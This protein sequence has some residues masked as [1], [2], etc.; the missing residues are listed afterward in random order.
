MYDEHY[1]LVEEGVA[2]FGDPGQGGP[3]DATIEGIIE[4][5]QGPDGGMMATPDAGSGGTD[6]GTITTGD[7]SH[8]NADAAIDPTHDAGTAMARPISGGCGC[9]TGSRSSQG[10]LWLALGLGLLLYS[11]RKMRA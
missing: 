1:G 8:P 2:W 5:T 7:A 6:A 10:G 11:R 3:S 9:S 4:V